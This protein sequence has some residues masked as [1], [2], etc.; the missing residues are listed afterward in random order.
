ML[1]VIC[2]RDA[3]PQVLAW[4]LPVRG[5][6][7]WVYL[8]ED[9][10]WR[11]KA[12]MTIGSAACRISIADIL[13]ETSWK[14]REPYIDWIGELSRLNHSLEWWGS[15]LAAKNSLRGFYVRI[16]SLG[17]ARHLLINGFDS[18]TLIV[19]STPALFE[20]VVRFASVRGVSLR[21]LPKSTRVCR[22]RAV[23]KAG[24][25]YLKAA[26]RRL[27]IL[28]VPLFAMDH[29]SLDGYPSY[30]R[31]LLARKGVRADSDFAG[32]DAILLF[33]WVDHRNFTAAGG[34]R[35][36]HLGPLAELLREGGYRVAYVPRVLPT[37]PFDEAVDRLLQTGERLFFPELYIS[38]PDRKNCYR[39]ARRFKPVVPADLMVCEVPVHRLACEHLE[40][41]RKSLAETL[42]YE[43]LIANLSTEGVHPRQIIYTCEGHSWEHALIWSVRRY[44]PDTRVVGYDNVNFSRMSLSMFPAQCE[45]GLRPLPDRLVTNGPLYRQILL[46]ENFRS[47]LVKVG[48]ALRHAYLWEIPVDPHRDGT[49]NQDS[50][51]RILTVTGIGFGESVELVIKA[52]TAFGDDP[53]FEVFIKCHPML[54]GNVVRSHLGVLAN[55]DNL[56]FVT[57]PVS[58][59]LPSADI[60][61]Y[62]YTS[63]CYEAL[64]HGVP[65]VFIKSESLLN[66]DQLEATPDVRWE[67]TTPGD[68]RRVAGEI[69]GMSAEERLAWRRKAAEVVRAALAPITPQSIEAFVV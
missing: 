67:A 69:D 53:R 18:P 34:Y 63:V 46:S 7:Q 66:L 3:D 4:E 37:I 24:Q 30:R 68:L 13:H 1:Y 14:L 35:D 33:T 31:R 60:M 44:M 41:K 26:Y 51:I 49:R 10:A 15:E 2:Q 9:T 61:L 8:G 22:W 12:E 25:R 21:R 28:T 16:C 38:D 17:V 50:T 20:E 45:Y 52:V 11:V 42:A 32:E 47:S 62:T 65:P 64:Q 55:H 19:C 56:H 43:C 59:L 6:R 27:C 39:Q 48:C 5:I 57:K 40:E 36:P 54:D 23:G 29:S 58:E